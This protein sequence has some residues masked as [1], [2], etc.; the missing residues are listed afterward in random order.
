MRQPSCESR[1]AEVCC[2]VQLSDL[3]SM[4]EETAGQ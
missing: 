3:L 1:P 2:R 4:L